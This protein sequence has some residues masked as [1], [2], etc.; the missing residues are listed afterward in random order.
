MRS[1]LRSAGVVLIGLAMAG[2]LIAV[3]EGI[4]S[5]IYPLPNVI[6]GDRESMRNAVATMPSAAFAV[7]VCGWTIGAFVGAWVAATL[8]D[9]RPRAHAAIV[10]A[11]LL[12]GG[13][14][15]MILLPHPIWVWVAAIAGFLVGGHLG[16]LL[17][18]R[19][20]AGGVKTA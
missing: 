7:V 6:P 10:I 4:N 1:F 11:V 19:A 9:R 12:A 18:T 3:I 2:V 20:R 15:N 8:A 13:I 17:A 14:A 16:V 5:R